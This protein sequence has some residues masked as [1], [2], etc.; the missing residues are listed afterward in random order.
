MQSNREC[1]FFARAVLLMGLASSCCETLAQPCNSP[2]VTA[3]P[4]SQT[5]CQGARVTFSVS[6]TGDPV[7]MFQWQK[8]GGPIDGATDPSYT[9]SSITSGDAGS[10]DVVVSNPCGSAV[11]NAAILT[12]ES[13]TVP[14]VIT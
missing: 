1:V 6:A 2:Q 7:L 11:S 8:D 13:D 3:D 10:Y 12:V 5:L 14:S 4:A 9:I